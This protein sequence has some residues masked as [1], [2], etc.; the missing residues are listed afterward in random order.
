[1][2]YSEVLGDKSNMD[3]RVILY[4]GYLIVFL[5]YHLVFILNCSCFNLFC[6]MWV[7]VC[8]GFIMCGCCDNYVGVW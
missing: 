7:C 1:V 5:L 4:R 8:V 2:R 6:N 3:I